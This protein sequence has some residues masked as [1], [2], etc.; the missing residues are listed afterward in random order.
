M[1]RVEDFATYLLGNPREI[2]EI[3]SE[4]HTVVLKSD[5]SVF[6]A[7]TE[8]T[9]A[10]EIFILGS[11]GLDQ[12]SLVGLSWLRTTTQF[13]TIDCLNSA[14][15]VYIPNRESWLSKYPQSALFREK[16]GIEE[17][18]CYPITWN[19]KSHYCF[20]MAFGDRVE[21]LSR[22][23]EMLRG[24]GRL[25]QTYLEQASRRASV[26]F[27]EPRVSMK[28]KIEALSPRHHE[29]VNLVL[30]GHNN[31]EIADRLGISINTVKSDLKKI[32]KELGVSYRS[33]IYAEMLEED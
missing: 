7:L 6:I 4:L 23:L 32:F 1:K 3:L 9:E 10:G 31:Q 13:P 5:N 33:Q 22:D 19:G 26:T 12:D 25:L 21:G 30:K 16:M 15:E 28:R 14:Q 11:S 2:Q 20:S 8:K 29:T 17:I 27:E 18:L 24:F